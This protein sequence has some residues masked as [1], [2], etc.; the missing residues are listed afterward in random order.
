[1]SGTKSILFLSVVL[2]SISMLFFGCA[3]SAVPDSIKV[4]PNANSQPTNIW[5]PLATSRVDLV[6]FHRPYQCR[7]SIY[8]ESRLRGVMNTYFADEL[9]DGTITFQSIDIEKPENAEIV[10]K[11]GAYT[12][13][14]FIITV[15]ET[16]EHIADVTLETLPLLD[17][18][19]SV[20]TTIR[21]KIQNAPEGIP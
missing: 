16:S 7:C 5:E 8:T 6:Y 20:A 4:N 15:T 10:E 2:I 21:A 14:L 18:E 19:E 3:A 12:S 1:M 9:E 17:D 11:C 13:Q